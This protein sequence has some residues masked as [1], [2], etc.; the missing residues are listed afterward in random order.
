MLVSAPVDIEFELAVLETGI[1]LVSNM[2]KT[3]FKTTIEEDKAI[4]LDQ[5]V[6]WRLYLAVTHRLNQKEILQSQERL[7]TVL[8][9]ILTKIHQANI[10]TSML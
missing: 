4:L 2:L 3:K 5:N 8:L 6:S 7:M 10:G 1:G 9:R